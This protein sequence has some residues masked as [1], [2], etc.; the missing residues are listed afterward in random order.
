MC[1]SGIFSFHSVLMDS[2]P[3]CAGSVFN[4]GL[5]INS[6]TTYYLPRKDV[7]D[8]DFSQFSDQRGRTGVK[9]VCGEHRVH[10]RVLP[11]D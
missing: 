1:V 4:F 11:S 3:N 9:K 5:S 8:F 6:L 2:L 10:R 7:M